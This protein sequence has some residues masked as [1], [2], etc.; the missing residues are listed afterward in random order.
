MSKIWLIIQREFLS[1]VRKKSFLLATLL[2]PLLFPAI[3]GGMIYIA[4]EQDKNVEQRTIQILNNSDFLKFEN[5]SKYKYIAVEGNVDQAKIV[6]S[7]SDDFAFVYIPKLDIENPKGINFYSKSSPGISLISEF[8]K[9]IER[10]IRDVKLLESGISQ[11]V[12]D[13]LKTNVK[14]NSFNIK[15]GEEKKSSSELI[16]GMGYVMGMLIYIFLFVYGNQVMQGVIEEKNS[17]IIEV[18]VSTVKPFHLMMGKVVGVASVGLFQ[19]MIW[20]LISIGVTM[21]AASYFGVSSGQQVMMKNV[22]EDLS[23]E[24]QLEA[25]EV[26]P[27]VLE[28]FNM[29][30]DIPVLKIATLFVF[31][32][33]G[34]YLLYGALFAAIG[35]AVDTPA[36][37]QQFM[38]PIMLPVI[39]GLMG[40]FMFVFKDPNGV[41]S[42][43]LSI[44]PFTSPIVM[45]GRVGFG[46]PLWEIVLS[47]GLLATGFVFT[48]WLAGRIY[49]VGILMH[50]TKVNYKV[51]A[52][53]FMMKN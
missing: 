53:W 18:I 13:K 26:N 45:M 7:E 1:R 20:V 49:R 19:F 50:G 14:I 52:K 28:V 36:D 27:E 4:L 17:K 21:G 44:I 2:V 25:A 31:Y 41:V 39:I 10:Q 15:D 40:L 46:V 51:L 6:F 5:S 23:Q 11:A 9:N 35:S 43:W 47:M 38:L 3:M 34:G 37:A 24:Q 12:L 33:L 16:S 8:E 30:S 22:M 29:I 32:F 48:I 42:F